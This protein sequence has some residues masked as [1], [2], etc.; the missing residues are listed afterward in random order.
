MGISKQDFANMQ[1]KYD[2]NSI[3][4]RFYY[5]LALELSNAVSETEYARRLGEESCRE[6]VLATVGYYQDIVADAGIWRSFCTL[7]NELY[8]RLLPFYDL[9]EDYIESE[10]NLTD[11]KFIVWYVTEGCI[12]DKGTLSPFDED[13]AA[14]AQIMF[15]YLDKYYDFAPQPEAYS[16][17]NELDIYDQ[18]QIQDVYNYSYWL[19]WHSYF[20]R[21]AAA[22]VMRSSLEEGKNIVAKSEDENNARLQ[23]LELNER[24]MKDHPTGPLAL[25]VGEW[26]KA[27]IE[28][29]SPFAA[30][31]KPKAPVE[32]HKFYKAFMKANGTEPIRF[33][34][35]A[36]ALT[37]F[38]SKDMGWGDIGKDFLAH[39]AH[40]RNFTIFANPE[41]GILIAPETAQFIKHKDNK[42]YSESAAKASA[43]ELITIPGR[44]PID[45][46]TY[47][48]ANKLVPDA[49]LKWNKTGR[50][51]LDNWDFLARLYLQ[52][53][54][55]A[56]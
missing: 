15:E 35:T 20:M 6:I 31:K 4:D 10:L 16:A 39:M 45:L 42:Y 1:P 9:G 11:L 48:F 50:V 18:E 36:A 29:K 27:I 5:G 56:D 12:E 33:V 51:L 22:D 44:C 7:H 26:I 53:Y 19:F 23:L 34:G 32:V 37:E 17:V 14:V 43:H 24:T 2:K 41:K 25:F 52:S 49:A 21:H 54:Y 3:S 30:P 55:R 47:V 38:L 8:G 13:I 28:N 40:F 46:V